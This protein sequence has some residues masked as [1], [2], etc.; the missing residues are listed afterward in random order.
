MTE[1]MLT[2]AIYDNSN[3]DNNSNNNGSNKNSIIG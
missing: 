1:K 2:I 3:N